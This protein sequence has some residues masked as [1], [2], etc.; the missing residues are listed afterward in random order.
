MCPAYLAKA[1]ARAEPRAMA[2]LS[3]PGSR[4]PD[5]CFGSGGTQRRSQISDVSATSTSRLGWMQKQTNTV[6][7]LLVLVRLISLGPGHRGACNAENPSVTATA[8][9][10]TLRL[11]EHESDRRR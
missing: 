10:C 8:A 11:P 5:F 1:A 4:M 2:P 3:P 6:G 9:R 7:S